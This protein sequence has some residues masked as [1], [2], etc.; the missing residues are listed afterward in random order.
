M[1]YREKPPAKVALMGDKGVSHVEQ[2]ETAKPR[3]FGIA[4]RILGSRAEAEDAVQ[5]TY[6]RWLETDVADVQSP[7]AFLTT[8]C[9]RRSIDMLRAAYRS[10][11]DYI[12]CWLPEPIHATTDSGAAEQLELSSS[13]STAFV[14]LLERLAPKERAAYVL[15]E[16]FELSYAEISHT[17]DIGEPACRKL[18]SRAKGRISSD[19]IRYQ[20]PPERQQELLMA[21]E[22]AV[23]TGEPGALSEL[24]ARDVRLIA[25][26]G[27]KVATILRV[28]EGH[29]VI[30]FITERLREWWAGFDWTTTSISGS[31]GLI[32]RQDGAVV[33]AVT[34]A[35]DLEGLATGIFIVRNPDKL[36]ALRR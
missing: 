23:R 16:I 21:F 6:L 35:Y 8:I 24:F 26:G 15:H 19:Q 29:E 5:D 12:G 27:G 13:L 4:Y 34:V 17:L 22:E 30:S 31:H 9:T 18:V 11:V 32:L 28:L 25:D 7:S 1:G 33:A 14:L 20:P 10:R 2:F 36:K 3:L